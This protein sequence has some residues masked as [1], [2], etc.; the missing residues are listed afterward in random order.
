MDVNY[1]LTQLSDNAERIA[2][3]VR[4]V[5]DAE[6]RWKPDPQSW[7]LLEV[8]NHLYDEE[9]LDFRVRLDIILHRPDQSWPPIDP[10]GWVSERN[11]N[12]RD[13]EESLDNFLRQRQKSLDWLR[14]LERPNWEAS[15]EA[16]FGPIKA[17]DMFAA[18]AT[19]DHLHMR[20][21]VELH[22]ALTEARA[23]PYNLDYAGPW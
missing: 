9:R 10:Q 15:Y 3:L 13:L 19:H 23:A 18:W 17:G 6:A 7:S 8:V 2:A 22:R 11:Y 16:S 14:S 4:G 21:L 12:Q 5:P 1:L 20:Q